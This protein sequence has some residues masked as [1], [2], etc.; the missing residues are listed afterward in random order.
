ML[1]LPPTLYGCLK[2]SDL[3]SADNSKHGSRRDFGNRFFPGSMMLGGSWSYLDS[4][5]NVASV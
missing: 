5:P 1:C 2:D 3:A 4:N